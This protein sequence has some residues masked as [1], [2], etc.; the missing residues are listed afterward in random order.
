MDLEFQFWEVKASGNVLHNVN[1]VN[2]TEVYTY[3]WL[4]LK[5]LCNAFYHIF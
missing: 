2:P 3:K 4:W 1:E 5:I